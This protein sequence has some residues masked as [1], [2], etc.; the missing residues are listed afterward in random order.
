MTIA[1]F[2]KEPSL[3]PLSHYLPVIEVLAIVKKS[4]GQIK[5]KKKKPPE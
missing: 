3:S 4:I 2:R 1:G 5:K